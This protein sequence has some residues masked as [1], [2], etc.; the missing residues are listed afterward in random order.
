MAGFGTLKMRWKSGQT[1]EE[2]VINVADSDANASLHGFKIEELTMSHAPDP[3][4]RVLI[5]TTSALYVG[6]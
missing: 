6:R 1:S 3:R 2:I 5:D 4:S